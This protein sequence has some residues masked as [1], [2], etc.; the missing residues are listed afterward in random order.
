M[1]KLALAKFSLVKLINFN[2]KAERPTTKWLNFAAYVDL[3]GIDKHFSVL[4]QKYIMII[5]ND[6]CTVWVINY[7][8]KHDA[9]IWSV[10]Y[11]RQLRS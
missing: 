9:M 3:A 7:D 10:T 6:V 1:L 11:S 8:H 2:K 4:Y 5:M